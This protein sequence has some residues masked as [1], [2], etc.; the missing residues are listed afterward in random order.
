MF[1]GLLRCP[2]SCVY[3]ARACNAAGTHYF[4]GADALPIAELFQE[5]AHVPPSPASVGPPYIGSKLHP[6]AQGA[7]WL[8][9]LPAGHWHWGRSR[10]CRVAGAGMLWLGRG[11]VSPACH[12]HVRQGCSDPSTRCAVAVE[13]A[14][15]VARQL[16][17]LHSHTAMPR[18][19]QLSS[20]PSPVFDFA[21]MTP[22]ALIPLRSVALPRFRGVNPI[23][24]K[25]P[26]WCCKQDLWQRIQG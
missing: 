19:S 24:P 25:K 1:W 26:A 11:W 9:V 5:C 18:N 6:C 10:W 15:A 7:S 4:E 14:C 12:P 21:D 8:P 17:H 22:L 20:F 23:S 3:S 13:I 2:V 16:K